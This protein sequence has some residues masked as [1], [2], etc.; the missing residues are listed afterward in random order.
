MFFIRLDDLQGPEIAALLTAHMADM[1]ATSPPE[2]VHA[3]DLTALRQPDIRFWTLWHQADTT[4]PA[5]LAGCIALKQ[6]DACY[7][8]KH[9]EIKSTRV[10]EAFRGQGCARILLSHLLA[11]AQQSGLQRLSLETGSMAFFQPAR[12][13]YQR[14]GFTECAPFADYAEDPN[15]VFMTLTLPAL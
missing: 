4:A 1:Q 3:L 10:A 5:T 6:L 9:G 11:V 15:S 2:S 14:F 12:A 13:L 8:E 7:G